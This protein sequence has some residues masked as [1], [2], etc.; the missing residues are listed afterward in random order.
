M[1]SHAHRSPPTHSRSVELQLAVPTPAHMHA[2]LGAVSRSR[3]LHAPWV[4]PPDS[5][6]AYRTYLERIESG[7]CIGHLVIDAEGELCGTVNL[8]QV[9]RGAYQSAQ[10]SYYAFAPHSGR[11]LTGKAVRQVIMLAFCT[12]GLN[13]LEAAIQPANQASRMLAVT[14]GLRCEGLATDFMKIGGHWRDHERW[15]IT[16]GEW[17]QRHH[18]GSV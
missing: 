13:R 6:F 4:E 14:A 9:V 16:A 5:P 3:S 8:N 17:R 10:L 18:K 7:S 15:A 1:S 12:Y 2:F 11:G